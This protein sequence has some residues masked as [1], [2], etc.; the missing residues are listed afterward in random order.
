M[1]QQISLLYHHVP[2]DG[3]IL[4]DGPAAAKQWTLAN[5]QELVQWS[6]LN[7]KTINSFGEIKVIDRNYSGFDNLVMLARQDIG[8]KSNIHESAIFD[9]Q[10]KGFSGNQGD[11]TLKQNE[12]LVGLG[13]ELAPQFQNVVKMMALSLF[14]TK[15]KQAKKINS[16][17]LVFDSPTVMTNE[18]KATSGNNFSTMIQSLVGSGIALTTSVKI[19]KLFINDIEIVDE[20]MTEIKTSEKKAEK[21]ENVKKE[22]R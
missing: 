15:S 20:L 6:M 16:L 7:P 4:Q 11:I 13:R 12:Y 17:C 22:K 2:L 9:T 3:I 14:G 5:N 19:A 1:A 8:A 21:A 18:Q 10:S